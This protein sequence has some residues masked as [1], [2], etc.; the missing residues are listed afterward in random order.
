[1]TYYD[2]EHHDPFVR[3]YGFKIINLGTPKL[4]PFNLGSSKISVFLSR[5]MNRALLQLFEYPNI[6]IMFQVKNKLKAISDGQF[7]MLI[8]IAVPH[9]THWGVAW[10][11]SLGVKPYK[12]WVADCGDPYMGNRNDSFNKFFYFSYLENNWCKKAD[13]I[14]IPKIEMKKSFNSN[15]YDKFVEIPQGFNFDETSKCLSKYYKN[16]VPTFGYAGSFIPGRGG[17]DPR[18]FIDF[19]ISLDLEFK[20]IVYAN[21]T[22]LL[23]KYIECKDNRIEIRAQIPRLQLIKEFSKLDFL[24]NIAFDPATQL[25]SKL[26]DYYLIN[27]PILNILNDQLNEEL[28]YSIIQFLKGD[29]SNK[30]F[31]NDISI[32]NIKNIAFKFVQL[33][34]E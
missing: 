3:E 33:G 24:V 25:P 20:F 2:K 28:K 12:K 22:F 13:F 31:I 17:R 26:I 11:H 7:D 15:Y 5:V 30:L 32:Y 6:Q 16:K 21:S 23:Q 10:A 34:S 4:K 1:M 18:P 9:P 14:S 27:R 19:L 8:S 29:Y